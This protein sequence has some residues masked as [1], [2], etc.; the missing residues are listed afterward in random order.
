MTGSNSL[1]EALARAHVLLEEG[2]GFE[3]HEI[4]EPHWLAA[5]GIPR[6]WLQGVIQFAA[7]THH[8]ER[9]RVAAAESLARRAADQL[10]DGPED[11]LGFPL[12]TLA[13]Q[14]ADRAAR[15]ADAAAGDRPKP[16]RR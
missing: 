16:A 13:R 10:R 11:W 1:R 2:Q 3:A 5:S 15:R 8:L 14:A 4:L 9:G 7:S 6:R 12:A